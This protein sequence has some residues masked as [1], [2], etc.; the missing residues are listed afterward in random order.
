VAAVLALKP[1]L[2]G[3]Q[4]EL[5]DNLHQANKRQLQTQLSVAIL[6]HGLDGYRNL[7]RPNAP[8]GEAKQANRPSHLD[9]TM[10]AD[11]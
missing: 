3:A 8:Q 6:Q 9:G 10:I 7:F 4:V 2:L 1:F 11:G 5:A